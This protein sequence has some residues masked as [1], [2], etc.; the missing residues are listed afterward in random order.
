MA[1]PGAR[2]RILDCDRVDGWLIPRRGMA[3]AQI[4]VLA[5]QVV[6]WGYAPAASGEEAIFSGATPS[7]STRSS[8]TTMPV[9]RTRFSIWS[10]GTRWRSRRHRPPRSRRS[11]NPPASRSKV[12]VSSILVPI[13]IM[14]LAYPKSQHRARN[15]G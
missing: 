6:Q 11:E 1:R 15:F 3:G 5:V 2:Y 10:T 13:I 12:P 8:P 7:T 4:F 14:S 9:M